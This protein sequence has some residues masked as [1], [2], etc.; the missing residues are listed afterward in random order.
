VD[1]E[2]VLE[3]DPG[4]ESGIELFEG[5]KASE[6]GFTLKVVLDDLVD[7]FDLAL[8]VSLVGLVV[9]LGGLEFSENP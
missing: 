4:R 1:A 8:A 9:E 6:L 3:V 7:G 2:V 5:L